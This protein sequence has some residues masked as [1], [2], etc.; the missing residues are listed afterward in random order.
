MPGDRRRRRH[1]GADEMGAAALSL[2]PLEVA[3]RGRGTAL[4]GIEPVG[5]HAE[6][7][8]A[9]GLAPLEAGVAEDAVEALFLGL[10][11]YQAGARDHHRHTDVR[12]LAAALYHGGR[13]TQVLNA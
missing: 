2:P 6:A 10:R 9:A 7:H 13:G 11:L 3:V 8:R 1:R 5:I 12:S 4:A